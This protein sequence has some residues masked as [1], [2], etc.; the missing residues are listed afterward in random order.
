MVNSISVAKLKADLS[1]C[2]GPR[3][4]LSLCSQSGVRWVESKTGHAGFRQSAQ[5]FTA[6]ITKRLRLSKELSVHRM[7]DPNPVTAWK[8]TSGK[9]GRL[10][11][12]SLARF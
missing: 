11:V 8:Y 10:M 1:L 12:L 5:A 6:D 4:C 2:S 9:R 7:P 3:S